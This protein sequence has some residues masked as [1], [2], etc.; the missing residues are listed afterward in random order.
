L[1]HERAPAAVTRAPLTGSEG[2]NPSPSTLPRPRAIRALLTHGPRPT[3]ARP[4]A[5]SSRSARG[6][7]VSPNSNGR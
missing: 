3:P 7:P 6:G 5:S 4:G 1:W 2:A